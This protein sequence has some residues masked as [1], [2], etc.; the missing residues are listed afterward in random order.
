MDEWIDRHRELPLAPQLVH[1]LL[2]RYG[3]RATA[4]FARIR[5]DARLGTPLH[6][7]RPEV[8]AEIDHAV[9]QE[10]VR[11][12][13][14]VM[15]RRTELAFTADR[16]AAAVP[17]VI[18]RMGRLLGWTPIEAQR[19]QLRYEAEVEAVLSPLGRPVPVTPAPVPVA[20]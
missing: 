13:S 6:P 19:Q 4:I 14:D 3:R 12:L 11:S 16:G 9:E 15:W 7:E 20:V 17:H 2:F 8:L 18:A 5:G 10:W 1:H